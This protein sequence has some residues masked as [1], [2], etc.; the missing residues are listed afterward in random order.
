MK[1]TPPLTTHGVAYHRR[2]RSHEQHKPEQFDR[3][4]QP[5]NV[6]RHVC[7]GAGLHQAAARPDAQ[8]RRSTRVI[9]H[10]VTSHR[11][12]AQRQM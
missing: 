1:K 8:V 9:P 12:A 10:Q 3:A 11:G 5:Q 2:R 6:G 4:G 7:A